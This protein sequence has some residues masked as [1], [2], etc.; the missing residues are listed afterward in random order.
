MRKKLNDIKDGDLEKI[1]NL[2]Y[3]ENE[4]SNT[5][6]SRISKSQNELIKEKLEEIRKELEPFI[7]KITEEFIEKRRK[8]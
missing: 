5:Y 4:K 1:K 8:K 2:L 6:L 7:K 3:E